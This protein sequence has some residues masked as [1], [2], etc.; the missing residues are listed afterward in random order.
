MKRASAVFL[1]LALCALAGAQTAELSVKGGGVKSVTL[2]E[3]LPFT[4]TAPPGAAR[5]IWDV[6][7]GVK[8]RRDHKATLEVT[9]APSG[10]V[11]IAVEC[12]YIDFDKKTTDS[13]FGAV[14]VR[15]GALPP[16]PPPA[17]D[18]PFA[19]AVQAA[20]AKEPAADKAHLVDLASLYR[21]AVKTAHDPEL[22]TLGELHEKVDGAGKL[23]IGPALPNVRAVINQSLTATLGT[24]YNAP[25]DAAARQKCSAT[26]ATVANALESLR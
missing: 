6:P 5:Y 4:V 14:T 18:D 11:T 13:K 9:A 17:P 16:T 8:Y 24:T 3:S 12:W 22:K 23:L 20:W 2:V 19:A 10:E 26:F 7:E 1:L 15:V 21:V 25:L